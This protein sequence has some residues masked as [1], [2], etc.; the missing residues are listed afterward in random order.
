MTMSM[1]SIK[2]HANTQLSS[3]PHCTN[4]PCSWLVKSTYLIIAS[5]EHVFT[6]HHKCVKRI[7]G[8]YPW[9]V[10]SPYANPTE[11]WTLDT[12]LSSLDELIDPLK[13]S[14]QIRTLHNTDDG[15]FHTSCVLPVI[16][17]AWNVS[18]AA[19]H[20]TLRCVIKR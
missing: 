2:C 6:G 12:C 13:P 4:V 19:T 15:N 9:G 18:P 14:D 8:D 3:N 17:N 7:P 5:Q 20:V 10:A 1:W 11:V 16:T